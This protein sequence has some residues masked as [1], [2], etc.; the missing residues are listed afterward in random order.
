MGMGGIIDFLFVI[1]GA[2]MIGSALMAKRQESVAT[3]I[4]LGKNMEE[5]DIEDK[6]GFIEYMYKRLLAAGLLIMV[7]GLIH[8]AND[9]YFQ[10]TILSWIGII[11]IIGALAVYIRA[12]RTG[13]RK[14]MKRWLERQ[15]KQQQLEE[16]I[17]KQM[18]QRRKK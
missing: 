5:K 1:S 18:K 14:Y 17:A 9:Y 12:Y 13:Q 6:A 4:M 16:E 7:S 10:S 8:L 3:N 11:G 2:Y 15:E